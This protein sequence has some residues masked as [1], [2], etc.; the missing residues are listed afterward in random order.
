MKK[1]I[2]GLVGFGVVFGATAAL[3]STQLASDWG[4]GQ[5]NQAWRD[6]VISNNPAATKV[7]DW[8]RENILWVKSL[9]VLILLWSLAWK[10]YSLWLSARTGS[11]IWFV[12]LLLV[13]TVGILDIL[14][15]YIFRK[16]RKA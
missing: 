15:I 7:V 10:G 9:V 4:W 11:K 16:N 12:V 6:G 1:L 13:N 5:D 3:A 8:I 2:V 14:Y